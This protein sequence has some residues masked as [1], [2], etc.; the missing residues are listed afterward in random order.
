MKA[1]TSETTDREKQENRKFMN[2]INVRVLMMKT[3]E[4]EEEGR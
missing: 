2:H 3:K 4:R 1:E